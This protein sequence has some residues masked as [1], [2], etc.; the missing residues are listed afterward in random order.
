[1]QMTLPKMDVPVNVVEWELFVPDRYRV[2]HFDGNVLAASLWELER[3]CRRAFRAASSAGWL[4]AW[5]PVSAPAR[6]AGSPTAPGQIVGRVVDP[7][8]AP[9]RRG[10]SDR[11]GRRAERRRSSPIRTGTTCCRACRRV[12]SS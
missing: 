3:S 2:D 8:G 11:R 12:R 10:D 5:L 7:S 6:A 1:M 4:A 9:T